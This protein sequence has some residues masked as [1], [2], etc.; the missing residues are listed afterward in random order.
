MHAMESQED[1]HCC[2]QTP[3]LIFNELRLSE[4]PQTPAYIKSLV[5]GKEL[6]PTRGWSADRFPS[7]RW[8]VRFC[9]LDHPDTNLVTDGQRAY[10]PIHVLLLSGGIWAEATDRQFRGE[11]FRQV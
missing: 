6:R 5:G 1:A 11:F 10:H 2:Y 7:F 3:F 8:R 4:P 9:G